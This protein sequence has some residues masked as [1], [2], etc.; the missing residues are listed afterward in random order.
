MENPPIL[1]KDVLQCFRS[2]VSSSKTF[3]NL[4]KCLASFGFSDNDDIVPLYYMI[5]NEP[6]RFKD[7]L[8]YPK[9]WK[10]DSSRRA[11]VSAIN[12]S[13]NLS[14]VYHKLGSEQ[15]NIIRTAFCRYINEL[16]TT[17]SDSSEAVAVA[18]S[19]HSDDYSICDV[20]EQNYLD[21]IKRVEQKNKLLEIKVNKLLEI[22][23]ILTNESPI[24][25]ELVNVSLELL[26][27]L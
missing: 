25:K 3:M 8:N 23:N 26:D 12:R 14:L 24:N 9:T 16:T 10:C 6:S 5:I 21:K 11:G 13:I 2:E 4:Q 1:V 17:S 19:E 7:P 20:D 27:M 22:L 15:V 18:R